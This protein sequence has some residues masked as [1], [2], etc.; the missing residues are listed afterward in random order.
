VFG[1]A[2][3]AVTGFILYFPIAASRA[4]PA[5]LIP[6]AKIMHSYEALLAFLIVLIWHLFAVI[7]SPEVFPLDTAI[8]TGR[9]S[10][11][12]LRHEHPL[13]Y[14]ELFGTDPAWDPPGH[15][16]DPEALEPRP[17]GPGARQAI[18]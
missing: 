10:R 4:L 16:S 17:G 14:E 9:I 18:D 3:M 7:L 8:F 12:R 13:E 1:G 2:M 5:E 6:A 15:A 11:E